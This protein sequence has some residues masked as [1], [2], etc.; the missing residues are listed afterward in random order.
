MELLKIRNPLLAAELRW[1]PLF[2]RISGLRQ[3]LTV[4]ASL[5]KRT[6]TTP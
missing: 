4:F 1:R 6:S 2:D 3:V 5:K